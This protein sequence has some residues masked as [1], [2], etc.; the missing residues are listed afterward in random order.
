MLF[1]QLVQD[2]A[3][4]MVGVCGMPQHAVQGPRSKV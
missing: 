4:G 1:Q 2:L 3:A